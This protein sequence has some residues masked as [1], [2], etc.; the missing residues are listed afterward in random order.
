MSV[1][2][3]MTQFRLSKDNLFTLAQQQGR[4]WGFLLDTDHKSEGSDSERALSLSDSEEES[5]DIEFVE[6]VKPVTKSR[7][8]KLA[9]AKRIRDKE[10]EKTKAKLRRVSFKSGSSG[11]SKDDWEAG[12]DRVGADMEDRFASRED[13]KTGPAGRHELEVLRAELNDRQA[14]MENRIRDELRKE[15]EDKL[16]SLNVDGLTDKLASFSLSEPH[17]T[18]VD[19]DVTMRRRDDKKSDDDSRSGG[20]GGGGGDDGGGPPKPSPPDPKTKAELESAR[21]EIGT[22]K[23]QLETVNLSLREQLNN[24]AQIMLKMKSM[25]P[26]DAPLP[27]AT[28]DVVFKAMSEGVAAALKEATATSENLKKD[29]HS[30]SLEKIQ[31]EAT[32]SERSILL[33]E[34][35]RNMTELQTQMTEMEENARKNNDSIRAMELKHNREIMELDRKNLEKTL[36]KDKETRASLKLMYDKQIES[37]IEKVKD[38]D[39]SKAE[40]MTTHRDEMKT[41]ENKIELLGT[42]NSALEQSLDLVKERAQSLQTELDNLEQQYQGEQAKSRTLTSSRNSL[43]QQHDVLSK[44]HKETTKTL[45][46][47]SD[48]RDSLQRDFDDLTGQNRETN[49]ILRDRERDYT[50]LR[51][52]RDSLLSEREDTKAR[53][54]RTLEEHQK[55]F[56][57]YDK[58]HD[59]DNTQFAELQ[60]ENNNL[61][62]EL[63][64]LRE[65]FQTLEADY[66]KEK[67]ANT[68][69]SEYMEAA[70]QKLNKQI[71]DLLRERAEVETE[72]SDEITKLT[73]TQITSDKQNEILLETRREQYEKLQVEVEAA[74]E[75]EKLKQEE[76]TRIRSGLVDDGIRRASIS[77]E[78]RNEFQRLKQLQDRQVVEATERAELLERT[79]EEMK[80]NNLVLL[81]EAEEVKKQRAY[82]ENLEAESQRR[83]DIMKEQATTITKEQEARKITMRDVEKLKAEFE[84][85]KAELNL[86]KEKTVERKRSRGSAFS[87]IPDEVDKTPGETDD[88]VPEKKRRAL[89][90]EL[91]PPDLWSDLDVQE[92]V[93]LDEE[94]TVSVEPRSALT[95]E[96]TMRLNQSRKMTATELSDHIHELHP[97]VDWSNPAAALGALVDIV[98]D[99]TSDSA[100]G[101]QL[102]SREQKRGALGYIRHRAKLIETKSPETP[103]DNYILRYVKALNVHYLNTATRNPSASAMEV[104]DRDTPVVHSADDAAEQIEQMISESSSGSPIDVKRLYLLMNTSPER[105]NTRLEHGF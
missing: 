12:F 64:Q 28:L 57:K 2:Y 7:E 104:D 27:G 79:V 81:K 11:V 61:D 1:V 84:Q 69:Q 83:A 40:M 88:L 82:I 87:H 42:S 5:S 74:R 46:S 72:H 77:D 98:V 85:L 35:K 38:T 47:T 22:L 53:H 71:E 30:L 33:E 39:S 100:T 14:D 96:M 24:Q 52:E 68:A 55:K 49:R 37:Y 21:S 95:T 32:L 34:T 90:S 10:R 103:L 56:D 48:E 80:Q 62:H 26:R 23:G 43:Q 58:D 44:R 75:R 102:T 9:E 54:T 51:E 73:Q 6:E 92:P 8:E 3:I 31:I 89:Q 101:T 67:Q 18:H 99:L 59:D 86:E 45:K 17:D 15:M 13:P 50:E 91:A 94:K 16:A 60:E 70:Q 41:L 97:S 36:A 19:P 66:K 20:G 76:L 63:E 25:A 93:D 105:L 29:H 78:Q 65:E 4:L